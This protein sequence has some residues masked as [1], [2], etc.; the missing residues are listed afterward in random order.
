MTGMKICN[1]NN[2]YTAQVRASGLAVYGYGC[3][4][5]LFLHVLRKIALIQD[6]LYFALFS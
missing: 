5:L 6:A 4:L 3:F 1:N 2:R